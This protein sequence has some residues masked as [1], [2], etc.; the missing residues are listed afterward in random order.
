MNNVIFKP[1][2]GTLLAETMD[3]IRKSDLNLPEIARKAK[4]GERWLYRLCN[5]DYTDGGSY[6]IERINN[7]LKRQK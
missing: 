3:L 6:K 1:K 4:V 5:G 2:P 7:F